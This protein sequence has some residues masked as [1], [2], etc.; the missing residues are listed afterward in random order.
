MGRQ[1]TRSR[2]PRWQHYDAHSDRQQCYD[3]FLPDSGGS[4][5]VPLTRV[6]SRKSIMRNNRPAA[7]NYGIDWFTIDGQSTT[8]AAT[9]M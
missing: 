2:S 4:S 1:W 7:L 8:K 3:A 9:K 6:S 5:L